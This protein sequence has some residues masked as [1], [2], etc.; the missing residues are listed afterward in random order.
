MASSSSNSDDSHS[1]RFDNAAAKERYYTTVAAKQMWP[2]QGFF[3]DDLLENYDLEKIIHKRLADLEWFKFGRQLPRANINWVREFYAHNPVG[4]NTMVY[5]RN[6]RVPAT[7]EAI[8]NSLDL[9]N[10]LPSIHSLISAL[11]EQ[12]YDVIKDYLSQ[13]NT[14]WNHGR[15]PGTVPRMNLLPEAKLWN[16]FVKRNIMPTSHNQTVDKTRLVLINA[17]IT[18][19]KFNVG[20]IIVEKLSEACNTNQAII[21]IPCL[22]TALCRTANV[23]TRPTDKYTSF[24]IG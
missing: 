24:R 23:P 11:E 2:E 18:G 17:I 7:A 6:H 22:I 21:A 4:E 10:D 1:G 8:N 15:N 16:T 20:Q 13:Q 3:Y 9:P 12:D 5:V 19:T 14:E